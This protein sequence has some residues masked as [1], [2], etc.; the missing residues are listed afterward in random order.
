MT[1]GERNEA[2]LLAIQEAASLGNGQV[3]LVGHSLGG[4]TLTP[5]AQMV[6]E[7]LYAVVYLVAFL[8]P[9][10]MSATV[11]IADESMSKAKVPDLLMA[12]P[13]TTGALRVGPRPGGC[14]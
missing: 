10:D 9:K 4:L 6:P 7:Q 14:H 13:E 3:V 1:Q 12:D 11:M 2:I 5:V 8:L